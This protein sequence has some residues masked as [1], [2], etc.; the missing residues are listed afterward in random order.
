MLEH[1]RIGIEE[2]EYFLCLLSKDYIDDPEAIECFIYAKNL[3][4]PFVILRDK[5]FVNLPD[6]FKGVNVIFNE[7]CDFNSNETS[8][9]I[10]NK[11]LEVFKK[12]KE[13]AENG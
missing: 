8:E 9:Y 3:G 10:S 5:A 4:K 6:M 11:L 2:S 12:I 7:S 1:N 13:V